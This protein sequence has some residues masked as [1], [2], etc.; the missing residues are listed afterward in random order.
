MAGGALDRLLGLVGLDFTLDI[1]DDPFDRITERLFLGA[2]P[3]PDAVPALE[4]AG[5][6]HVVSCL[7]ESERGAMGFLGEHFDTAF[8]PVHDGMHEDIGAG[9]PVLFQAMDGLGPEGRLLVHC[10]VGVSRSATLAIGQVMRADGLRFRE[11]YQAVRARRPQV[12]PN[13]G[14]ASALQRL[15][16]ELQGRRTDGE[17]CSLAR[18]LVA[19]CRAPAE[20]AVLQDAL[21][22]HDFDAVPALMAVFDGEIPRVVQGVR[23]R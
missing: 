11:A 1:R 20:A 16:H 4:A 8:H 3:G 21:E 12:L 14:F 7:P 13:V 5:I 15:E 19:V 2:R 9:F 22:R 17:P 6:T 23:L 18:Y 10:E